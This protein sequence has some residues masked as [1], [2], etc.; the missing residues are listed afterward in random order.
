MSQSLDVT[1]IPRVAPAELAIALRFV[2]GRR[3]TLLG[4]FGIPGAELIRAEV[5]FWQRVT[6]DPSR[7]LAVMLRF[8]SLER[9]LRARRIAALVS[10]HGAAAVPVLLETAARARLNATWGFNPSRFLW[11]LQAAFSAME[12]QAQPSRA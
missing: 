5:A 10:R 8:R 4:E 9:V 11:E 1:D 12:P 7:K 3:Q 2:S 6:A